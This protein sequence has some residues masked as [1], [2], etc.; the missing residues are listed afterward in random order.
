M[1]REEGEVVEEEEEE[2]D[3]G[4]GDTLH[5]LGSDYDEGEWEDGE[6]TEDE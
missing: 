4:G 3:G 5:A 1:V 6:E 2:V